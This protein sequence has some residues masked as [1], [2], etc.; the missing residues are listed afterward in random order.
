MCQN[1]RECKKPRESEKAATHQHLKT[2]KP[3]SWERRKNRELKQGQDSEVKEQ[4]AAEQ[5]VPRRCRPAEKPPLYAEI[6]ARMARKEGNAE[7]PQPQ[8]Q[9][10]PPRQEVAELLKKLGEE[11][12]A[13]ALLEKDK[14]KAAKEQSPGSSLAGLR[15]TDAYL[16]VARERVRAAEAHAKVVELQ[17]AAARAAMETSRKDVEEAE[18][19]RKILIREIHEK[20]GDHEPQR[21]QLKNSVSSDVLQQ[22][23][24]LRTELEKGPGLNQEQLVA[25]VKALV[26][27]VTPPEMPADEDELMR[28]SVSRGRSPGP[29][30]ADSSSRSPRRNQWENAGAED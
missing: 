18:K 7:P 14:V 3:S 16:A 20:E 23:K 22:V 9:Q 6:V 29:R 15:Q 21:A 27:T 26:L 4:E 19:M 10:T 17:L 8:E 1:C 28:R 5:T 13:A 2:E 11:K 24:S 12:M 30:R 25:L